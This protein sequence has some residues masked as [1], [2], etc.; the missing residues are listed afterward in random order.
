M[1]ISGESSVADEVGIPLFQTALIGICQSSR[2]Q[3][4]PGI[5][6]KIQAIGDLSGILRAV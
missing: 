1:F 3:N 4:C 2:S 5:S 6:A